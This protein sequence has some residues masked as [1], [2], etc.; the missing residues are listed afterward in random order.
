[1]AINPGR[2][3]FAPHGLL[4]FPNP[5]PT[6]WEEKARDL[7]QIDGI[8]K[9]EQYHSIFQT[10]AIPSRLRIT[11]NIVQQDNHPKYIFK[12][13]QY[14]L[15]LPHPKTKNNS[16]EIWLPQSPDLSAIELIWD[17]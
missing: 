10:Y 4:V 13:C 14:Y 11:G 5:S 17:E 16:L 6:G 1:M 15:E 7:I 8:V 3:L 2:L 12:L 9:E